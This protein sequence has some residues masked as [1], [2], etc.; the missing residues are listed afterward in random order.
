MTLDIKSVELF[1]RAASLGAFGRAGEEFQLSPTAT[2]QRIQALETELGTTLF[3]RTTRSISLTRDGEAFLEHARVILDSVE[4]AHASISQAKGRVFGELRVTTSA[5]FGKSQIVPHV[6][7]FLELYPEVKLKLNLSDS[8]VD[9]VEQGYDLAIRVGVL[10]SS[11]LLARKLALNPRTLVASPA[12]LAQHGTPKRPADLKQHNCI[13]LGETRNWS[14]RDSQGSVHDVRA[15]GQFS[16]NFGEAISDVVVAGLGIGL[17][18]I[19]DVSDY[20]K[21]GQLVRVLPD[22][23]I[24]P[25]W[26]I[27]AVRP[28]NTLSPT[29]VQVFTNFLEEKFRQAQ[30]GS[31]PE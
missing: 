29:R 24:E 4:A 16:T 21:S 6:R 12:Y 31:L 25:E 17:K 9:I 5:S 10:A 15:T 11:T 19:W 18:S 7:E 30:L 8:I 27:W 1:L 28:P 14:L 13:T 3:N 22:Y 23:S 20:L 26:Q 2:T